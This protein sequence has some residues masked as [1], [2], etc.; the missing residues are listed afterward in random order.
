M[1]CRKNSW[2][3]L[4]LIINCFKRS[5]WK[6][7]ETYFLHILIFQAYN[8]FF[9]I[10]LLIWLFKIKSFFLF[11]FF[12]SHFHLSPENQK[13]QSKQYSIRKLIN[14]LYIYNIL[15]SANIGICFSKLFPFSGSFLFWVPWVRTHR[16]DFLDT[17]FSSWSFFIISPTTE[18][19]TS[20]LIKKLST[21]STRSCVLLHPFHRNI[22]VGY[23]KTLQ[24]QWCENAPQY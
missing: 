14:I 13:E 10:G 9:N 4:R 23:L 1:E 11:F 21:Q 22:G 20:L 2:H 18:K 7:N 6:Q 12:F 15:N 3:G 5:Y 17:I 16:W 19:F 24:Y 8:Y